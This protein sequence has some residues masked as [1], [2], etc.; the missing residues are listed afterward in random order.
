[1]AFENVLGEIY[2][3]IQEGCTGFYQS[4]SVGQMDGRLKDLGQSVLAEAAGTDE[5]SAAAALNLLNF[6]QNSGVIQK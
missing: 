4:Y 1:M 6:Y 5:A 2:T 3:G